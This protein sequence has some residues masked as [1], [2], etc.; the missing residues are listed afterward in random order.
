MVQKRAIIT[1]RQGRRGYSQVGLKG[2][3]V[4]DELYENSFAIDG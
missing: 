2:K 3:K 4:V 1:R